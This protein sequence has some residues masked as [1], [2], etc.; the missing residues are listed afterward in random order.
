MRL[1]NKVAVLAGAGV[2]MGR[3]TAMLFAQE[4]ASVAII[5]R[6]DDHLNET[7]R[8]I[9]SFGGKCLVFTCDLT[10]KSAVNEVVKKIVAQLGKINILYSAAGGNFDP[11]KK[12]ESI[13]E[14]YWNETI[15]VTMNSFYNIYQAVRPVMKDNGGGS[16]ITVAASDSVRQEG[17]SAYGAAKSGVIGLSNHLAKEIYSDNIRVN[18]IYAGLFRGDLV[19]DSVPTAEPTL[20]RTG[21]PNDI[22]YASL[23]FASDESAWVTGQN[24]AVD[25]G[26]DIGARPL[27][28]FEGDNP[29]RY[30]KG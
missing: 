4:G 14:T 8:R 19:E 10:D 18:C 13:E 24:L 5:A 16:I 12:A 22:A 7:A 3:A 1:K 26:V 21:F 27:W 15:S 23:F 25:G 2:R 11:S 9:E 17:N 28:Q 20:H 6:S 30:A 29:S